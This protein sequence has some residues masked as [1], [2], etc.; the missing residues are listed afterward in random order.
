MGSG[1]RSLSDSAPIEAGEA[2]VGIRRDFERR[3]VGKGVGKG[4]LGLLHLLLQR[5]DP[6]LRV[7]AFDNT[8]DDEVDQ[9]TVV[10]S[11]P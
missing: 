6:I 7:A 2:L 8:A 9:A 11:A 1:S 3:I 10:G 4:R 5:P